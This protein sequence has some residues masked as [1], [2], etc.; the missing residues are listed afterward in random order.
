MTLSNEFNILSSL[1]IKIY[2]V[3]PDNVTALTGSGSNRIYCRLVNKERGLS[4][5]GVYGEDVAEN[6]SFLSLSRLF[7]S[8]GVNVPE[9]LIVDD[10]EKYYLQED[11]GDTALFSFLH[12]D[13]TL[14]YIKESFRQL[15]KVQTIPHDRF[16]GLTQ[17]KPFSRRQVMW[18]LNYFKYEF[19]KPCKIVFDED[20]L[21]DDFESFAR[22]LC[23][24]GKEKW[25]FMYRDFQSR[26]IMIK[27][28]M[29]WL[30]DYQGGRFGPMI[31]DAISFLWQAKASFPKKLREDILAFYAGLISEARGIEPSEFLDDTGA[32]A[33]FRNMQVLGAYGL[34][35][36]V[37]KRAHFLESIPL[38]LN[39]LKELV[40][41]GEV[42]RY[43][44]LERVLGD[45]SG[46]RKFEKDSH[47]GLLVKVF[48]F[49]YKKGYPDDFTGNGGG[50]MFDCRSM[51]NPGRYAEYK[52]LTGLDKEVI[53]FLEKRGEVGKFV[54]QAFNMVLP[55]VERYKKRGFTDLQIGFGCTGG[56]HRSVY[57]A[58]ALSKK[59]KERFPE[60]GVEVIHRER[61]I[62][63]LVE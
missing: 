27:D 62:D 2:T 22:R 50:F 59:I 52:S 34:R 63:R 61:G 28:G 5:I 57:C 21:E 40:E 58:E 10:S 36:L 30:I 6:R 35:G 13:D 32:F 18:D 46:I 42:S 47:D 38:A 26:N 4:C 39:N 54:A 20:A 15:V 55:A 19:L 12:S 23:D 16:R 33:L 48:S 29:P 14:L 51:H 56:Q 31:Y 43:P 9:I 53:E 41:S 49:S 45:I 7:R 25:G 3:A 11:L 37:E 1:F 17:S 44:E 60:V 8:Q 24:T